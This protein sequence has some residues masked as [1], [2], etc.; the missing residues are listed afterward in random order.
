MANGFPLSAVGGTRRAMRHLDSTYFS[1]TY[2]HDSM[3]F[4]VARACLDHIRQYS[5]SEV[6]NDFGGRIR[7]AFDEAASVHGSPAR[8]LGF[9]G[10]LD[11]M[12]PEWRGLDT[13]TQESVF[14]A[15]LLDCGVLPCLSVFSCEMLTEDDMAQAGMGF[16]LAF[17]RLAGMGSI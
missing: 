10:R 8:A 12:F 9:P 17:E 13:A 15:S 5:V 11:L 4:A 2:R 6:V 14:R 16:R 3:A 1:M 7:R